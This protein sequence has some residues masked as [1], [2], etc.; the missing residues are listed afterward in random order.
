M[1]GSDAE[2]LLSGGPL[3]FQVLMQQAHAD[4]A[5]ACG[6]RDALDRVAANVADREHSW[7]RRLIGEAVRLFVVW[8]REDVAPLV[9]TD[10]RRKPVGE[11]FGSDQNEEC[12]CSNRLRRV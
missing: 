3:P 1:V 9:A 8:S 2:A 12:G 6:R 5:L 10:L 7:H 11:G 4:S